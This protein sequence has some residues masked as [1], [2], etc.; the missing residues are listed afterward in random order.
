MKND[1]DIAAEIMN[2]IGWISLGV[3]GVVLILNWIG[4]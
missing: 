3:I 1:R 4:K 2:A